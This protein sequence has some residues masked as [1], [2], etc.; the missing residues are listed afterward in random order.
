MKRILKR[1][2]DTMG[3]TLQINIFVP[4]RQFLTESVQTWLYH[5]STLFNVA[6]EVKEKS[7]YWFV[8]I[9]DG[10]GLDN[11]LKTTVINLQ[12]GRR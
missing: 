3:N 12:I 1:V 4:K 7:N 2:S 5:K 11:Q 10:G 8:F 9:R 6:I